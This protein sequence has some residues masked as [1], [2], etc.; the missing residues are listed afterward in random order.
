MG[1]RHGERAPVF[2]VVGGGEGVVWLLQKLVPAEIR[3][4]PYLAVTKLNLLLNRM[5]SRWQVN[6]Y[7]LDKGGV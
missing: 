5:G 2:L 4:S 1:K 6:C 7:K 3:E